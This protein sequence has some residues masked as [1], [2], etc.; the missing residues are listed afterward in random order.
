MGNVFFFDWEIAF[1]TWL[2]KFE[3]GFLTALATFF[4]MLGE[5][6]LLILI[7]GMVYWSI[8][9]RLGRKLT[10]SIGGASFCGAIVKSLVCRRRP[11]MDNPEIRCIRAPAPEADI[12][13]MVAQ[14]FSMP[15]LH[16]TMSAATYGALAKETG[17]TILKVLAIVFPLCIGLSRNYLGVH[18]PTDVI[19]GWIIGTVCMFLL[20]TIANKKGYKTGFVVVLAVGILGFFFSKDN[21]FYTL[22]GVV[23]GALAGFIF[24]EKRVDFQEPRN[25]LCFILRP[26]IGVVIFGAVNA[27][28]KLPVKSLSPDECKGFLLIYRL[29]RYTV[30]TFLIM[31]PYTALF[32]RVRF[33]GS[34]EQ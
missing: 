24:E 22:Y 7:L 2:Q 25:V 17:K 20:C 14:G 21:E 31:G 32:K 10:L 13:S 23:L 9:K 34:K 29:G 6:T 27:L 33:L 12:M 19:L 4:T 28:L 11:Y 18:Y 16:A 8:D 26:L 3:C 5:E 30:S 15:S 1:M